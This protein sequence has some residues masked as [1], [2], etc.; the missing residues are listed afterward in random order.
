MCRPDGQSTRSPLSLVG[1][2]GRPPE[3]RPTSAHYDEGILPGT[4]MSQLRHLKKRTR[5]LLSELGATPEA[6]A[7]ALEEA[8]IRGTP[9]SNRGCAIALYLTAVMGGEPEIRSIAVGPCSLVINLVAPDSG[10]P[11]GRLLVQLP[12][13]V[14]QFVAAFDAGSYPAIVRDDPTRGRGGEGPTASPRPVAVPP[15]SA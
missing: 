3:K 6:V 4:P 2:A 13:P 15:P 1:R 7:R 10:R 5:G 11:A 9:K 14:R 12:K 8:G